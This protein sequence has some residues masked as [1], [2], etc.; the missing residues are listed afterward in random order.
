MTSPVSETLS[1]LSLSDNPGLTSGNDTPRTQHTDAFPDARL[2]TP[3][4]PEDDSD[5]SNVDGLLQD[6]ML[7][8][9]DIESDPILHHIAHQQQEVL[10]SPFRARPVPANTFIEGVG[11]RL[12]KAAA[13]RQGLEWDDP[14]DR[15]RTLGEE[16]PVSF[17]NVPGHK[18]SGLALVSTG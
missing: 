18:R 14:R 2:A 12:S 5:V 3:H 11:P 10:S 7:L 4:P 16:T 17:E 6:E 8:D 13:L 9:E 15:R 1:G